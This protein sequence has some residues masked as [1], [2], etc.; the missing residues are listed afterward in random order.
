MFQN[1]R[2]AHRLCLAFGLMM[3]MAIAIC[4][5]GLTSL[6]SQ[7]ESVEE[8]ATR[9]MPVVQSAGEWHARVEAAAKDMR[10]LFIVPADD[11]LEE[12]ANI[13]NGRT[14]RDRLQAELVHG[15]QSPKSKAAL[16]AAIDVGKVYL[17][18]ELDFLQLAE[19][20]KMEEARDLML[21]R[22]RRV[23]F[24]YIEALNKLAHVMS[25]EAR[26]LAAASAATSRA[27]IGVMAAVTAG[28]VLFGILFGYAVTR[29]VTR[30][31]GEAVE[32]AR[33]VAR[34]DLSVEIPTTRRDE[35]GHLLE[36]LQEMTHR[37]RELVGE[38]AGGAETV[39]DTSAQIAQGHLDLSQRTEEQ[40]GTLEETASSMEE[41]TATVRQNA[42]NA[43]EANQLAAEA[44]QV[45]LKGGA[46]V[47]E[48]VSTMNGISDSSR[49]IS[50]IIGV[51]DGIAFQTNILALN[52]AVEAA[53]AGEQ[54]RGFAVV[55]AEVRSLAQRSAQAA[56]EIKVLIG[57]SVQRVEAGTR[58]VGAAGHTMEDIV[59]SVKKV[60]DLIAGIAAASREQSSGIEQ[61][62][63]A[64][65][66][67]DH[68]VQQNA[69]LVEEA[70]AATESMKAQSSALL[71]LVSRFRLTQD[72]AHPPEPA[73]AA[74]PLPRAAAGYVPAPK[75]PPV[76][77]A[78]LP[79]PA[80]VQR[81]NGAWREF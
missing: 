57:D 67:M 25:A 27:S 41:L 13:R 11:L 61:V 78:L 32:A 23:Q 60:S 81:G 66:Q 22:I 8:L 52:A 1:L 28:C 69:S 56:R 5:V 12:V 80:V 10:A 34:G 43:R 37:L 38:V 42:D 33:R 17:Q 40:A 39:A 75:L 50:E 48:V 79:E 55:A 65:A 24:A 19:Q 26:E 20:G 15:V 74:A 70:T 49:R 44:S 51:I 7:G 77:S 31:V 62:N 63:V 58:L 73:P 16:R 21:N 68:V 59:V 35:I 71:Q 3:L 9:H 36:A 2:L 30:P 6:A 72:D 76:L 46:V 54:G 29:S 4:A 18:M 64:V 45:A 47:G 14:E 53:R